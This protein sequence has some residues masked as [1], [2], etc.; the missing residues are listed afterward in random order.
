[1]TS[2][3]LL[4]FL[5]T[6]PSLRHAFLLR[7]DRSWFLIRCILSFISFL[8]LTSKHASK[9]ATTESLEPLYPSERGWNWMISEISHERAVPVSNL[10]MTGW[11]LTPISAAHQYSAL[12]WF[13]SPKKSLS[14]S[15]ALKLPFCPL[16][17]PD[18][19]KSW[20]YPRFLHLGLT[21]FLAAQNLRSCGCGGH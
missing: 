11:P 2:S 13:I 20:K 16:V 9:L 17:C 18:R 21:A 12:E 8:C 14:A 19:H 6:G 3:N 15:S 1:M 5:T 7:R 4:S 10:N